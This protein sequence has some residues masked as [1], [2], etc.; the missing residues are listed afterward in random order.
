MDSQ[1]KYTNRNF[2]DEK[3]IHDFVY[4]NNNRPM[5]MIQIITDKMELRFFKKTD[6]VSTNIFDYPFL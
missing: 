3:V 6:K 2:H 1:N 5:A 4:D